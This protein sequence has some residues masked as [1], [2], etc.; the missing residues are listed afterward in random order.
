MGENEGQ[1][2]RGSSRQGCKGERRH[3]KWVKEGLKGGRRYF[4]RARVSGTARNR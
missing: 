1:A 2:Q 4:K 3:S